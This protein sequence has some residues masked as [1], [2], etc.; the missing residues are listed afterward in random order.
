MPVCVFVSVDSDEVLMK[1]LKVL[2]TIVILSI[3]DSLTDEAVCEMIQVRFSP[4][5]FF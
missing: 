1:L 2:R 3:G 5:S 4:L